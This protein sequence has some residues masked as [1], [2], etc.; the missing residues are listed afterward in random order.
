MIQYP[1]LSAI[2]AKSRNN[3]IG[4]EGGLPWHL[5]SDLQ[6]FKKTTLGKPV[7]MGRVTWEGLPFALPGRPNLVLTRNQNYISPPA[8]IFQTTRDLIG[9]GY[10]LAGELGVAVPT[11]PRGSHERA[12]AEGNVV[13]VRH[14]VV[15]DHA[16]RLQRPAAV[17]VVCDEPDRCLAVRLSPDN[18]HRLPCLS[19]RLPVVPRPKQ[20]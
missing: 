13:D 17:A 5:S 10:E 18:Q 20:E 4:I 1:K 11:D 2:V 19:A 16:E 7:L 12:S 9:R 14:R 3:V 15:L 6:F 8:E